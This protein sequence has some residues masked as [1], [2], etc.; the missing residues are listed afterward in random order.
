MLGR[1]L[2]RGARQ[3]QRGGS[4]YLQ[5][6]RAQPCAGPLRLAG[7]LQLGQHLGQLVG[8][9][10]CPC[11]FQRGHQFRHGFL[12]LQR[13]QRRCCNGH[14][15]TQQWR[16]RTRVAQLAK[17]LDQCRPQLP[18]HPAARVF[19]RLDQ[20]DHGC[21]IAQA[22]QCADA[23]PADSGVRIVESF[24]QQV[25]AGVCGFLDHRAA[26][27]VDHLAKVFLFVGLLTPQRADGLQQ[28]GDPVFV[29]VAVNGCRRILAHRCAA[30]AQGLEQR[31]PGLW[32]GDTAQVHA[33][34]AGFVNAL[35]LGHAQVQGQCLIGGT[36]QQGLPGRVS[37]L[38]VF[39]QRRAHQER[40]SAVRQLQQ[41]ISGQGQL[42]CRRGPHECR[43][44]LE[45]HCGGSAGQR[46]QR[47]EHID[48]FCGALQ[49]VCE[50]L[51][52]VVVHKYW[53]GRSGL[54]WFCLSEKTTST[55]SSG[56]PCIIGAAPGPPLDKSSTGRPAGQALAS[57]RFWP[58]P[59]ARSP[60]P[61][62]HP[63]HPRPPVHMPLPAH[64]KL[65]IQRGQCDGDP[66]AFFVML[67][68]P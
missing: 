14:S 25:Q 19:K 2:G 5:R 7:P 11:L 42:I 51:A 37:H 40:G 47:Q 65:R 31:R 54:P 41:C 67:A 17:H 36:D 12:R 58:T 23:G 68:V 26:Q 35:G 16:D 61:T 1:F 45:S 29:G 27:R 46:L 15:G 30:V 38:C 28:V 20:R 64:D 10:R 48:V 6:R 55:G 39:V 62:I 18:R 8:I 50:C 57:G 3:L 44:G 60:C 33:A 24:H 32:R 9:A 13:A 59:S 21:R 4:A 34:R 43:D 52:W 22:P 66:C 53:K 63:R 56:A 49:L